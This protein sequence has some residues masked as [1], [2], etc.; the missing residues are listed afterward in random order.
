M[1]A[2]QWTAVAALITAAGGGVGLFFRSILAAVDRLVKAQTET[3]D[4]IH[5]LRTEIRELRTRVDT[6]LDVGPPRST[7]HDDEITPVGRG[8][9]HIG[10]TG[11]KDG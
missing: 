11:R 7:R 1:T 4:G 5:D 9:Y 8:L 10:R 2:E 6:L 3:R